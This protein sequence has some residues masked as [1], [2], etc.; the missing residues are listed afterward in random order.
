MIQAPNNVAAYG[1]RRALAPSTVRHRYRPGLRTNYHRRAGQQPHRTS[2]AF[3]CAIGR[4]GNLILLE[5]G[6]AGESGNRRAGEM[7][8]YFP[9]AIDKI[10]ACNLHGHRICNWMP[11]DRKPTPACAIE[12]Y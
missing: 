11:T 4:S 3:K 8:N 9:A 12:A 10:N 6:T 7:L 1:H 5:R 2:T